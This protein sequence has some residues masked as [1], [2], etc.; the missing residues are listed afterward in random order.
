MFT[1][2]PTRSAAPPIGWRTAKP[3]WM[4]ILRSRAATAKQAV[5]L[6]S[7]AVTAMTPRREVNV[8]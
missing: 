2:G 6:S 4:T 5:H 7:V 1:A 3:R 8:R